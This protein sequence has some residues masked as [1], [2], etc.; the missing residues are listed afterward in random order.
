[1]S[2]QMKVVDERRLPN[3]FPTVAVTV[4]QVCVCGKRVL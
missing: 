4:E 1:M 3:V 2:L